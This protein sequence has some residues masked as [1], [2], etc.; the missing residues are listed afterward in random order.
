MISHIG[1]SQRQ[2]EAQFEQA[3]QDEVV[4]PGT[5]RR[6]GALLTKD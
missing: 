6:A 5:A 2:G 3:A 4:I 1:A